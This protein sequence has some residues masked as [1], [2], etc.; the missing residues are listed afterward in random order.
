MELSPARQKLLFVVIVVVLAIL[1]YYVMLPA[2]HH[3]AKAAA[4][5]GSTPP[6]TVP[7]SLSA[8]GSPQPSPQS[9]AG[10]SPAGQSP[11]GGPVN[12]YNW[13]PF[14][15]QDLAAAAAVTTQFCVDY[16]TYTYTESA[17]AYIGKMSGLV[18]SDLA[19]S[20]ESAYTAPGVV[21]TRTGQKQISSGTATI[22]QL[23]A[24]G[25]LSLTFVVTATQH[26]VG[27]KGTSNA[28]PQFAVTV[29]GSGSN[30]Q[31]SDI[32]LASEGNT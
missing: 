8:V 28:S 30:W 7:A 21:A 1:G 20:L 11:S 29:T 15:E 31:V 5:A 25:P 17:T 16:D 13:L 14:T 22:T 2:L 26:I 4:A 27:N 19:A 9:P 18:V 10:Q 3:T 24:F 23:R 32:E 6:P 12:I